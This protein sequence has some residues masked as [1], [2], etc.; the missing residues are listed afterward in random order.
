MSKLDQYMQGRSINRNI[1][2]CKEVKRTG[3]LEK[4][5]SINRN[6][7]ECKVGGKQHVDALNDL[8]LIETSWNVKDEVSHNRNRKHAVLIETS[9]NV[10]CRSSHSPQAHIGY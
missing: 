9:W 2:E 3:T 7:V 8:V 6:I 4:G 5:Y 10:K 1:V